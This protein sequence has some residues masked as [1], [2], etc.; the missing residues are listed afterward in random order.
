MTTK[1]RTKKFTGKF[2]KGYVKKT[3][4]QKKK[5]VSQMTDKDIDIITNRLNNLT[6]LYCTKHVISKIKNDN[7]WF[8]SDMIVDVIED[9]SEENIVE[10]N[11][12]PFF[13]EMDSRVLLRSTESF[14]VDISGNGPVY[15]N[16]CFVISLDRGAIVTVYYN[17]E[18]DNHTYLDMSRYDQSLK[19]R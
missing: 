10:Y 8:S 6:R 12:S 2:K 3:F 14:L 7:L 11:V 18:Y 16:I 19:V 1:T 15:C 17:A 4:N 5:H 9:V 13:G